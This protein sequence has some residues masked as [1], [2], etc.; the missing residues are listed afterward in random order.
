MKRWDSPIRAL[1]IPNDYLAEFPAMTYGDW[2]EY[3]RHRMQSYQVKDLDVRWGYMIPALAYEMDQS[4][5]N[6]FHGT[7]DNLKQVI[8]EVDKLYKEVA[9]VDPISA[10]YCVTRF[11]YRPAIAKFNVREAYHL[12]NIRTSSNA[13]PFIRRLMWPLYDEINKVNPFLMKHLA[14]RLENVARPSRDSAWSF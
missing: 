4:K 9:K 3:K 7:V 11:H 10:R 8:G 12:L 6:S 13:H 5:D 1:E 14:L 2:R